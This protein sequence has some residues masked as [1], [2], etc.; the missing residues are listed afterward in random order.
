MSRQVKEMVLFV[1]L[2]AINMIISV[3]IT[4]L[5]GIYNTIII[6]TFSLTYGDIT[7]EVI[8]FFGLSLIEIS[9]YSLYKYFR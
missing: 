6:R 4:N 3:I 7:W 5:L 9:V 1:A 8:I 2:V